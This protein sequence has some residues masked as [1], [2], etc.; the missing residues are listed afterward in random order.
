M[1]TL[2]HSPSYSCSADTHRKPIST[3]GNHMCCYI[4]WHDVILTLL[5]EV[6]AVCICFTEYHAYN[7]CGEFDSLQRRIGEPIKFETL[8]PLNE[9]R[10]PATH[11]PTAYWCRWRHLFEAMFLL[12]FWKGYL[13]RPAGGLFPASPTICLFHSDSVTCRIKAACSSSSSMR[14]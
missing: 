9:N 11:D 12:R 5:E 10:A 6:P 1:K 4:C 13:L 2:Y 8:K 7:V 14:A 3:M